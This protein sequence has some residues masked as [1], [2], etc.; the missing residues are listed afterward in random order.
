M[1]M[2]V[3]MVRIQQRRKTMIVE[4][5]NR[6]TKIIAVLT[7]TLS[8]RRINVIKILFKIL[9]AGQYFVPRGG[10]GGANIVNVGHL[11]PSQYFFTVIPL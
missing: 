9:T 3:F 1:Q 8:T 11:N 7:M 10:G 6:Y 5:Q 2:T 4:N